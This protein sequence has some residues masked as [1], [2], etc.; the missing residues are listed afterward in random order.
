VDGQ[1][2]L[3]RGIAALGVVLGLVAVWIDFGPA[4]FWSFD[5]SLGGL[6]LI[7]W[8]LAALALAAAVM[9]GD[10]NY[11]IAYGAVAG[12]GF[13]I[14]LF[15]PAVLAFDQWDEL[16]SGAFLGLCSA[17][18]FIGSSIATW[19]TDRPMRRPNAAGTVIALVGLGLVVGGLFPN[20]LTGGGSYWSIN[21]NGHSFGILMII[22]VVLEA[23]AIAAVWSAA[24]GVDSAVLLGGV[25]LGAAIAIPDQSAFNHFGNLGT[26]AWLLGVG[27]LLVGVGVL[28]MWLMSDEVAPAPGPATA[29]PTATTT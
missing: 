5:G 20:F 16:D 13:G 4:S 17:L 10:R 11:D 14:Y 8:I 18:A 19:S 21:G 3:G 29:P 22:L 23:L 25:I 7:L 15:Y 27:G 12:I 24:A 28:L 1:V 6:L 2:S 26:G 9:T